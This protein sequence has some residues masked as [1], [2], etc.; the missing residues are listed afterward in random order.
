MP[1]KSSSI[2]T[3]SIFNDSIELLKRL[4]SVNTVNPPGNEIQLKPIITQ[5]NKELGGKLEIIE[6]KIGRANF[7]I[8]IGTG[9]PSIGFFPHLDTV[10]IGDGWITD[11]FKATI[12]NGRLYARGAIDSKGNFASSYAAVKTFIK[13]N[14]KFKGTIILAGCADEEAGSVWGMKYLLKTGF[15]VD[16]GIVPDGGFV[17]KIMIGEKGVISLTIKS[18]GKQAHGSTPEAGIN[19]LE[20]LIRFLN[21]MMTLDITDIKYHEA[22]DGITRTVNIMNGGH[23]RNIIP[24]FAEAIIDIRFPYG[25]KKETIIKRLTAH[26]EEFQKKYGGKIE[27]EF[28]SAEPHLTSADSLLVKSFL[29]GAKELGLPMRV[30]T[31]G[32]ITDAKTLAGAGFK[33]LVH[34]AE[35]EGE[36]TAHASNEFVTIENL[37]TSAVLYYKLLEK[38]LNV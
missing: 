8:K 24:G 20:N 17:D 10:A 4:V 2:I 12:K 29:E 27:I 1:N 35:S 23:G 37:R 5:I 3:D 22:F 28:L 15:K 30:G 25:A 16:Y 6:G 7:L 21:K 18:H 32:G 31:M 19:A 13:L 9:S 14:K 11:P 34:W 33:T 38:I 36:D 26:K